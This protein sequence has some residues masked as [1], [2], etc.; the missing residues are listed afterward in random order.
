M[1]KILARSVRDPK[2]GCLEY[3]GYRKKDGYG[4]VSRKG[5]Q[6]GAHRFVYQ[7]VHGE[8]PK[9][10]CVLHTCDNPCCVNIQHLW[11][12][13]HLDNIADKV[14]K[15]RQSHIGGASGDLNGSRTHPERVARGDQHPSRLHPERV[16]RGLKHWTHLRPEKIARGGDKS[17]LR[18][19]DIRAIRKAVASGARLLDVA[20]Q[21]KISKTNVW[22]I[23]H[24]SSW[25]HVP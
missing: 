11:I 18:E 6:I 8:I 1:E 7:E 2:T 19:K 4:W 25:K 9:G 5:R 21:Y 15:G 17:R 13:T 14:R 22:H 12:G 23:V 20:N 3:Q 16:P 24:K 10:M